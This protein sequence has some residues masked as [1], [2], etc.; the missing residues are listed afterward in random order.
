MPFTCL[1]AVG[2]GDGR[3]RGCSVV[4]F[5][6]A[7]ACWLPPSWSLILSWVY[8]TSNL[9]ILSLYAFA[10]TYKALGRLNRTVGECQHQSSMI[11]SSSTWSIPLFSAV[12]HV[13][14]H[15]PVTRRLPRPPPS[16]LVMQAHDPSCQTRWLRPGLCYGKDYYTRPATSWVDR[17]LRQPNLKPPVTTVD[18]AVAYKAELEAIDRS[19]E[20]L[21]T[22][23]L[24]PELTPEE[25]KKAKAAGIIGRFDKP[26]SARLALI[27]S[28][29]QVIPARRDHKF[30]RWHRVL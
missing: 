24:S 15:N 26:V 12:H 25:I 30:R 13:D 11:S 23:Y 9:D 29:C 10:L 27:Q 14:D 28:R 3:C 2:T 4:D 21:M 8:P 19:V 1:T 16:R 20:Y 17:T 6:G 7:Q 18:Q 22:L 5:D